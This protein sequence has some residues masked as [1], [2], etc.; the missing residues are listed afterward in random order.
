MS[1][2]DE[3]EPNGA[4]LLLEAAQLAAN[5]HGRRD[6]EQVALVEK[7]RAKVPDAERGTGGELIQNTQSSTYLLNTL[8]HPDFIAADASDQRMQLAK[9]AGALAMGVDA[10]DTI[11]AGTSVEI[12]L[13]HQVVATH[14]GAMRLMDSSTR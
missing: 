13:A 2:D 10:A 11:Q 5:W 8:D 3:N 1:L 14:A 9:K 4:A 6:D 7:A 12:M